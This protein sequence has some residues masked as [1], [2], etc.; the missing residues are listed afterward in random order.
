MSLSS[1]TV[2]ALYPVF[3]ASVLVHGAHVWFTTPVRPGHGPFGDLDAP[4]KYSAPQKWN[5][6]QNSGRMKEEALS[7]KKRRAFFRCAAV[8]SMITYTI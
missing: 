8:K 4:G 1:V 7:L 5:R 2:A 6:V 3:T